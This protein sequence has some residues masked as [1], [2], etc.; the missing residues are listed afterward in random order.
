MSWIKKDVRLFRVR[1]PNTLPFGLDLAPFALSLVLGVDGV[2]TE[3]I[4]ARD[5]VLC[6]C[7]EAPA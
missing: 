6:V 7:I 1:A 5:F 3:V 2:Y 4:G